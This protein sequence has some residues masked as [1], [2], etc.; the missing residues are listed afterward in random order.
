[1]WSKEADM[2]EKRRPHHDPIS[3]QY[4]SELDVLP[5]Y[6]SIRRHEQQEPSTYDGFA[7]NKHYAAYMNIHKVFVGR[8]GGRELVEIADNLKNEWLPDYLDAG[9]WAA[10]EAGLVC[11]DMQ[12]IERIGLVQLAEKCWQ[13]AIAHQEVLDTDPT[14]KYLS[15]A[16]NTYRLAL[17]LAYTPM[18]KSIISGN[19]TRKIREQ[20]FADTLAIAQLSAVQ[21]SL[22]SKEGDMDSVGDHL[23]LAHECNA[24][25][26][27]LYLN[28][29]NHLPLPSTYRAGSGYEYRSQTHDIAVINQHWGE[30]HRVLPA[31]IKA[32]ASFRDKQRYKALIVRGK[33]H[34][35]I[36][37]KY[38]PVETTDAFGRCFEGNATGTDLL[39]VDHATKTIKELFD[40]YQ[41]GD[42]PEEFKKIRTSTKFHTNDK[43]A[44]KYKEFSAQK[45]KN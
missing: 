14:K 7:P 13:D 32:A 41:K 30:I 1:M 9:G 20:T 28:D 40:L 21:L 43:L 26:A 29:P 38:K 6:D 10:A 45:Q 17:S 5:G 4:T 33:M 42:C 3:R 36:P 31:E 15:E 39:I 2:S 34:L 8:S 18:M 24:L 19:V 25:L 23:G 27:L 11:D 22:A 37:G 35:S 44:E 16:T 12:T